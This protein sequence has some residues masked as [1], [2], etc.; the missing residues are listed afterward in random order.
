MVRAQSIQTV[1]CTQDEFLEFV[2][3]IERYA[4]A[5]E[6]IRPIYWSRR[7]GDTVEF[8]F[9]PKLPGLPMPSPKLVQRVT[10][11]AGQRIDITNAPLPHNKIGNRMSDFHA[12]FVCEPV[13]GGTRVTRTIEMTFPALVKWLVNHC[14][15]ADCRLRSSANSPRQRH[16]SNNRPKPCRRCGPGPRADRH[17]RPIALRGRRADIIPET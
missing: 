16:T 6:K 13:E 3:D 11:T 15:N 8:Q 4:K 2:M 5:D 14:S 17:E 10:L 1:A 9:R 12:S 7:D